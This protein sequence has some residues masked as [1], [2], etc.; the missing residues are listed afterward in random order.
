MALGQKAL[1][2]DENLAI[3]SRADNGLD[4]VGCF[5]FQ[6]IARRDDR[7]LHAS[8]DILRLAIR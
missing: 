1:R 4:P 3:A 2:V 6:R 8:P 5:A 7:D